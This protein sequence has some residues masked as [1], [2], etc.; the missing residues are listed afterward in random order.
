[1]LLLCCIILSPCFTFS[2]FEHFMYI[3]KELKKLILSWGVLKS[4]RTM[5]KREREESSIAVL[6]MFAYARS[7]EHFGERD[8][9][10]G[11]TSLDARLEG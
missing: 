9:Q 2:F 6:D 1:M 8:E 7:I 5:Y 3:A 4:M 11:L 10:F